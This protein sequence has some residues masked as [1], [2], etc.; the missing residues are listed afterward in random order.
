MI[1]RKTLTVVL[2][3]LLV[4]AC[5]RAPAP[6]VPP[7]VRPTA[8]VVPE[9]I[10]PRPSEAP[11]GVTALIEPTL[12]I[13]PPQA[14][15]RPGDPGVQL[16]VQTSAEHVN[17]HDLTASATWRTDAPG[18]AIVDPDGY[19]RPIGSGTATVQGVV[20]KEVVSAEIKVTGSERPWDF[21]ADI[22]PVFSRFGCNTG[23]CHGRAEGQN[24]F[25]LALFGSDAEGDYRALTRDGGGRRLSPM[26]PEASLV[27]RKATGRLAHGGGLRLPPTSDE[28]QM[29]AAWIK[30]GAPSQRGQTHGPLTRVKVE[31]GDV[32]LDGPG[33]VQLRVIAHY[34]DGHQR[35]VTRLAAYKSNDDSAVVVNANGQARLLRRA[36]TDLVVRYQSKVIATRI[37]T[38]INPDLAFDFA[39]LP[40]NNIIDEEL[41]KR[42]E[43]L[44]VPPSP[45]ASDA[46][47][48]RRVTLDLTGEYPQTDDVREFQK[49]T[50]PDKRLALVD[51]LL[52]SKAFV[53]FWQIKLGDLLQISQSRFGAGAGYYEY[54]LNQSLAKNVPWDQMVRQLLTS[55]GDPTRPTIEAGP[56]NYALDGPDAKVKAEQTAQRFLGL[57]MRCAQCH[58]H[59]FD[60]W[61]RDEYY[62]L[63]AF[64]A[65]T[66]PSG[67]G[68][69]L[70]GRMIVKVD[71][72]GQI[73]NPR[74]RQV[75]V[76]G[77]PGGEPIEVSEG[78][79]PRK[80]LADW[81]TKPDNPYFARALANWVWAQL[82]GKGLVDPADNL[83]RAN[84][85]V[86]PELLDALAR[87]VVAQKFDLRALIRTIA[88]S[89]AYGAS[90]QTVPGNERD[91]RLFSHHLP[92]PLTA[93]QMA[94]A[95]A[96]V[97][98]V[99][100]RF[101]PL[102]YRKAIE[103]NDPGTPSVILDT[104]G[105]CPRTTGCASVDTPSLSLRQALLVIGGDVIDSK[106]T[107][108]NGYLADLLKLEPSPD[109]L[110][111]LLYLRALCRPPTDEELSHWSAELAQSNTLSEAA[112][113]L[114]WALLN[115]REFAFNH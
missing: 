100:D 33:L 111:E 20:G 98:G 60:V 48:L 43:S 66:G 32:R 87:S 54:W 42:L 21:A 88:V 84:P 61:T 17:R 49:E 2:G 15:L 53:Q 35:D 57:R 94:G 40:R 6:L 71:P 115:S 110:V 69:G 36:E 64:F 58:D 31:P 45:A 52:A 67:G 105:R 85:P 89:N 8:N 72:N 39:A 44:R 104:F 28:Y 79:D 112:E 4:S 9:T 78:D 19:V 91:V 101:G 11:P 5:G 73:M 3:L 63:A 1:P 77:L 80:A 75:A 93:H 83:S 59:P 29:L 70:M 76:P 109:E 18:V 107:S 74:T 102:G 37:G 81:M 46:A 25:H 90:S 23:G 108:L 16:R 56:I 106:V 65:K 26:D 114:F 82:F 68:P 10:R 14:T 55:V 95:L 97:T 62:S 38:T 47:F 41:Y 24:G 92:R 13:S 22:L 113:D 12:E 51:R 34:Q 103:I 99:K 50:D 86:H 30:A 96:Q 27:L 7:K